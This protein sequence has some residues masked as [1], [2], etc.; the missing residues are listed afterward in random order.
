MT[1]S[2]ALMIAALILTGVGAQWIAWRAGIP[3][4]VLLSVVGL[5]VGPGTGLIDPVTDFGPLL[6]PLVAVAVAVILF[7]GGLALDFRE[8]TH[9]VSG[10]IRL[11]TVAPLVAWLLGAG[12]A[13]YLADLSWPVAALFGGI[14]IVT[15]PT[16]IAPLLRHARLS[17]RPATLLKWE[18]IV[19]DPTGALFAVLAYEV[20]AASQHG[21]GFAAAIGHL[22]ITIL[23]AVAIGLVFGIGTVQVF[24][25][26]WI[27]EFLK[28]PLVLGVLLTCFAGANEI[29][30]ETGLLAVTVLGL[31]IGNAHLMAIDEIRRFKETLT[32]ILVSSVFIIL[33]ATLEWSMIAELTWG[34][35][36]FVVVML[37]IVRPVSVIGSLSFSKVSWK[38][39]LL[40]GWIAPRGIVAVAVSGL[41]GTELVHLG[42]ADG[43]LL[44]PLAFA[45]VFSTVVLHGFS[46]RPMARHLDLAVKGPPGVLI[47]GAHQW[48]IDLA[49]RFAELDIPVVIADS[50]WHSLRPA[51]EAGLTTY[52][53]EV[54]SEVFEHH[55]D[56]TSLGKLIAA[57]DNDAYNTLVCTDFAPEFGRRAVFQTGMHGSPE[58]PKRHSQTLGGLSL[59]SEPLTTDDIRAAFRNGA[60]IRQTKLTDGFGRDD[61]IALQGDTPLVIALVRGAQ[62]HMG[63]DIP[64]AKPRDILLYLGRNNPERQKPD[65]TSLAPD[66]QS[67]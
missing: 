45:M 25:R 50:R 64:K 34:H 4:I 28:A 65:A 43:A 1:A 40:V 18:G 5:V 19:N 6:Q 59:F 48:T 62:L 60:E 47:V 66:T 21:N 7:E 11:T 29:Q 42:Y 30:E 27:P 3:G 17:K 55:L 22:A 15:G 52:Y 2:L 36:L 8:L 24:K 16:V 39:R 57:T 61:F 26:G 23:V 35:G 51:R 9:S 67:K 46:I 14:M 54:L 49:K 31:T 41:F 44:I 58:D 38:E 33:T 53:G 63:P 32:I 12:A 10:V 56:T 37:F 13:H 20:I